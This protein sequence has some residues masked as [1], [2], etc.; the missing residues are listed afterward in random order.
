MNRLTLKNS[1]VINCGGSAQSLGIDEYRKKYH[2]QS[3]RAHIKLGQL[4]DIE[5]ELGID[6][7]L[8]LKIIKEGV[9]V[10]TSCRNKGTIFDLRNTYT[11]IDYDEK[12]FYVDCD[13]YGVNIMEL[14]YFKDYGKTWALT[15]EELEK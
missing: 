3:V 10:K 2:E 13:E 4:E 11:P 6:L 5:E 1:G 14:F 7:I 15:N 9:F 12:G 8:L